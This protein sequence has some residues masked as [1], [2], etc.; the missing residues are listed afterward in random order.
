MSDLIVNRRVIADWEQCQEV[1]FV[2]PHEIVGRKH[3]VPFYDKLLTYIPEDIDIFL[4]TNDFC[5][6]DDLR[7]KFLSKGIKNTIEFIEF[8]NLFDIWIR[9]YAPLAMNEID[10]NYGM[11]FDYNPS[12]IP[13]K[14]K[15]QVRMDHEAGLMLGKKLWNGCHQ[16]DIIWDMGNLT[17][18]GKGTAI[19]T[20]RLIT[21]NEGLDINWKNRT[22]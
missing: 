4:L 14:Y 5:D 18:N 15:N 13:K 7:Q 9:D 1:A 6:Y 22:N 12:Y 11:K 8:P 10:I 16:W 20:N 21:D 3:L 2:Y 17:H 19:I